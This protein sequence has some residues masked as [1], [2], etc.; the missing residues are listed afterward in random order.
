MMEGVVA[1]PMALSAGA[2]CRGPPGRVLQLVAQHEE[3]C[4]DLRPREHVQHLRRHLRVGAVVKRERY[5]RRLRGCAAGALMT[6][7]MLHVP[8]AAPL[9]ASHPKPS[10]PKRRG[11]SPLDSRRATLPQYILAEGAFRDERE[12][13]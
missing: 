1:D 5:A 6:R 9:A 10:P 13:G 7:G 11:E 3:R 2:L 8:R 12:L 4:L